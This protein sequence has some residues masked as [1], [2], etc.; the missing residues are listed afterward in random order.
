MAPADGIVEPDIE[1]P[2]DLRGIRGRLEIEYGYWLT[3]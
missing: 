1:A 2:G 3:N